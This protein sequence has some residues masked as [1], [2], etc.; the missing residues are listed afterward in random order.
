MSNPN[1]LVILMKGYPGCGKSTL[2][3]ALGSA[4]HV[5]VVDKDDAKDALQEQSDNVGDA[6]I[7]EISYDIMMNVTKRQLINGLSVIVDSPLSRKSLYERLTSLAKTFGARV[8]VLE[9]TASDHR[10]WNDRLV[11]RRLNSQ[12]M[13]HKPSDLKDVLNLISSYGGEDVWTPDEGHVYNFS[14]DTTTIQSIGEQVRLFDDY[15]RKNNL[16][17]KEA[18]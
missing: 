4:Y 5:P 16:C 15:L 8:V 12:G 14:L 13:Y 2:A 9:C 6:T 7:N 17:L 11:Q 3:S 10:L 18:I 1:L